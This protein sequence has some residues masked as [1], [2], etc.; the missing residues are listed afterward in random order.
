MIRI[1]CFGD[2]NTFGRKS[3]SFNPEETPI[4]FSQ[5]RFQQNERWTGV[6]ANKLGKDYYVIE[7]GLCGRTTVLDDPVGG[8]HRNGK[9]YLLPCLESH[10]PLDLVILMLGTNDLKVKFS[11]S[12][13]DI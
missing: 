10:A 4:V 8:E 1:L 3:V 6:M 7:E 9:K 12:A 5:D 2:S 13:Y 11:M